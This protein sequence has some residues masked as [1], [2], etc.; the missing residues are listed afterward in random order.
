MKMRNLIL[1]SVAV[2]A[3]AASSSSAMA[4]INLSDSVA[5]AHTYANEISPDGMIISDPNLD[6]VTLMGFGV[7]TGRSLYVRFDLTNATFASAIPAAALDAGNTSA[8]NN[9]SPNVVI[10]S[11]G[12]T[13]DAYVVF[14]ITADTDYAPTDY[15]SFALAGAGGVNVTTGG[16]D[17]GLT[18]SLY[19]TATAAVIGGTTGRL[20]TQSETIAKFGPG[21]TFAVTTNDSVTSFDSDFKEFSASSPSTTLAKLGTVNYSVNPVLVGSGVSFVSLVSAATKLKVAGDFTAAGSV[22]LDSSGNCDGTNEVAGIPNAD[23]TSI[24]LVVGTTAYTSGAICYAVNATTVL[25]EQTVTVALDLALAG[26]PYDLLFPDQMLGT[27]S[28]DA[29]TMVAPLVQI[30]S[31]WLSRL[32]LVNHGRVARAYKVRALSVGGVVA[33][34]T[35]AALSGTLAANTTTVVDLLPA[36][37]TTTANSSTLVVTVAAPQNTVSGLYQ[38]VNEATGSISNHVLSYK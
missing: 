9:Y 2:A 7:T 3:F 23:N 29:T 4:V 13:T 19:E 36:V 31:G 15:F 22:G 20:A 27:I 10:A 8:G 28:H 6:T 14:Q 24:D 18:Y 21:L 1:Q 34:L 35:G 26:S 38:I 11:G 12:A 33:T 30:S 16:T 32:V 37:V 25:P 17:V 5:D